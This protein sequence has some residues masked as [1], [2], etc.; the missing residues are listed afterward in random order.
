MEIDIIIET[1]QGSNIK[2]KYDTAGRFYKVKKILPL[3]MVF[4]YHFGFIPGTTGE[5]GDPLDG[6]VISESTSF[7]G[8]HMACRLIGAL[9]ASQ[10]EKGKTMRNDRYFFIPV[11]S[12]VFAHIKSVHE[13]G[14]RHNQQLKD[15]F[16]NYNLAENK[17]FTPLKIISASRALSLINKASK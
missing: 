7:T 17:K 13:F 4:P 3:G 6:M 12:I 2:Y 9:L 15:F 1:V 16:I 14:S 8:A 5:D 11:D 10:S